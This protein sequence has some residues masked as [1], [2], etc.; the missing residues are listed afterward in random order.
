MDD[1]AGGAHTFAFRILGPLTASRD[2]EPLAL[3]S[4]QQRA[5]L[6]VLIAHAGRVV[7]RDRLVDALWGDAPGPAVGTSIR[8]YVSH[9]RRR[10]RTGSQ[11][12]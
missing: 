4:P 12:R 8:A 9:L 3:G 10:P 2:G 11:C 1:G 7:T 6:A 5:L